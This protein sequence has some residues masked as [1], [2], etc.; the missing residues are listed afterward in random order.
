M[1]YADLRGAYLRDAKN[2]ILGAQRSDGY[3]FYLTQTDESEWL[4]IAGCQRRTIESYR[5]HT[6]SYLDTEKEIETNLILDHLEGRLKAYIAKEN[7]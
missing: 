1:T 2:L 4:V 3:Q 5:E 7:K 6:K